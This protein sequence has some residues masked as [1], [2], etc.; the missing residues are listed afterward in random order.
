MKYIKVL[1][2]KK[3]GQKINEAVLNRRNKYRYKLRRV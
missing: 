2:R 1:V 3:K